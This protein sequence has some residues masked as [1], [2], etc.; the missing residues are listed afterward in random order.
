MFENIEES[1][2]AIYNAWKAL[3]IAS[4]HASERDALD[5]T[6]AAHIKLK[7]QKTDSVQSAIKRSW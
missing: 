7:T 1:G 5:I 3:K 6:L 4:L 2:S